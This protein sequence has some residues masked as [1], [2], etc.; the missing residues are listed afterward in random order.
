[1]VGSIFSGW[2]EG[3]WT[4]NPHNYSSRSQGRLSRGVIL[5]VGPDAGVWDAK[6]KQ[7]ELGLPLAVEGV[8][9]ARLQLQASGLLICSPPTTC[10][11]SGM[12][13]FVLR[14]LWAPPHALLWIGKAPNVRDTTPGTPT[15]RGEMRWLP[16]LDLGQAISPTRDH[17]SCVR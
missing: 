13:S 9:D 5:T 17:R 4:R 12:R 2:K 1:M 7:V 6:W 11:R 8:A 16:L 15:G 10:S 3:S 14:P